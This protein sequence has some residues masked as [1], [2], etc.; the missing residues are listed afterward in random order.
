[1][2]SALIKMKVKFSIHNINI[3]F[4]ITATKSTYF[5]ISETIQAQFDL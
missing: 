5:F 3:S 1:M 2:V 4:V